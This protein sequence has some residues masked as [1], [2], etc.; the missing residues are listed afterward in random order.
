MGLT[1]QEE[2][3]KPETADYAVH[4]E[5]VTDGTKA[6]EVLAALRRADHVALLAL[7]VLPLR[8]VR[9]CFLRHCPR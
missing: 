8:T 6:E 2:A 9:R 1:A 3:A 4:A 5:R 7:P